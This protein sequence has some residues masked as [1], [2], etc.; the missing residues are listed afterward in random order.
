[1]YAAFY[2]NYKVK[3]TVFV[4]AVFVWF[5]VITENEYED[6][7]DV[8]INIVQIPSNK[9]LLN[10]PPKTAKV[11]VKGSGKAL[12]AFGLAKNAR[13]EI[14]A[15]SI[16]KARTFELDVS[17]ITSSRQSV[18]LATETLVSPQSVT[19]I[20]DD[21]QSKKI[22]V[23]PVINVSVAPG[24]TQIES[25]FVTPDSVVVS[26]PLSILKKINLIKTVAAS[27][28]KMKFDLSSKVA[29]DLPESRKVELSRTSVYFHVNVQK[30]LD[31]TITDIPVN[32]RNAPSNLTIYVVP[33]T[34]SLVVQG[35]GQVISGLNKKE[36]S[37][38]IDYHKIKKA[39]N[40][41]Y[42]ATIEHPKSI[43]Y[44]DVT[45]NSFSL[46]FEKNKAVN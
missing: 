34:L 24:F 33:S 44:R 35:G 36:I 7:V 17:H 26:G 27:F 37:A 20:L 14:D 9:V 31:Y 16:K 6:F 43:I 25:V 41:Q 22:P 11:K 38:Y 12:I 18:T 19:V 2:H 3:L 23:S 8:P 4:S 30:L 1:M 10:S 29:L 39:P 13:I 45:P 42:S 15:S 21:W 5:F 40:R 32:V 28:K 46:V